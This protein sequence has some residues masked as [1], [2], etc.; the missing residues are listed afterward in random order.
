MKNRLTGSASL[1]V[2]GMLLVTTARAEESQ[3]GGVI[4]EEYRGAEGIRITGDQEALEY[5]RPVF[6]DEKVLTNQEGETVLQFHDE[7][8]LYVGAK[9]VVILDKFVYDPS[10]KLGDAAITF[11]KGAFRFV[12]GQTENEEAIKLRTPKAALVIRGTTVQ[13][14]I[15]DD[16]NEIIYDGGGN[17][18]VVGCGGVSSTDLVPGMA[19][20]LDYMCQATLGF[21]SGNVT[22]TPTFT[23][24]KAL[25][26]GGMGGGPDNRP[27]GPGGPGGPGEPGPSLSPPPPPPPPSGGGYF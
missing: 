16:G 26:S 10:T 5:Q 9:S 27:S 2:I 25:G 18:T 20:K 11:T 17:V 23:G 24:F 6:S 19:V 14:H 4:Q 1:L 7:S 13:V 8:K 21:M 3:I 22:G 15:L 12:S